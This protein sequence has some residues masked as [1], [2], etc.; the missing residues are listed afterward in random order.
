MYAFLDIFFIIFHSSL[1]LFNLIGWVWRR[2]R[3]L[4]LVTIGLTFFSW[5]GLGIFYGWGYCPCTDWHWQ[6][7]HRLG[8]YNLPYSYIKY[9][10]DKLTGGDWNP[11]GVDAAVVILGFL[12]L[13]LSC[14]L[15]LKEYRA[16]RPKGSDPLGVI[17]SLRKY[18]ILEK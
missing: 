11:L 3:R 2:T 7:K 13:V 6:V 17:R 14:W 4:H 5:F 12:A 15:N 10:L 9:Y 16:N 18:R 8:E 1:V